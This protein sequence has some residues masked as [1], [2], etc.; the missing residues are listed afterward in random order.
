MLWKSS[1]RV[2]IVL[3]VTARTCRA[4]ANARRYGSSYGANFIWPGRSHFSGFLSPLGCRCYYPVSAQSI[5]HSLLAF[6][7]LLTT[8]V[9]AI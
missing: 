9:G 4:A 8:T 6:C 7:V 1:S 5:N 3:C 2:A